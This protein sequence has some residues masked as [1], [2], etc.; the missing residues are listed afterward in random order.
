MKL[1]FN[2]GNQDINSEQWYDLCDS[3]FTEY[4]SDEEQ[5]KENVRNLYSIASFLPE[6]QKGIMSWLNEHKIKEHK[7]LG[8]SELFKFRTI[9]FEFAD[10]VFLSHREKTL[11]NIN[12]Q[13]EAIQ[14]LQQPLAD[15]IFE[16][17]YLG[18]IPH[19]YRDYSNPPYSQFNLMLEC[20]FKK[21]L[22][23][24]LYSEEY[25]N[26]V[27]TM[28]RTIIDACAKLCDDLR[29]YYSNLD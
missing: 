23:Y 8:E 17:R 3:I 28:R 13:I 12:E 27:M 6:A 26:E 10:D 18:P 24:E 14:K 9:F 22:E 4:S 29:R 15:K 2:K 25:Y 5:A 7:I 19:E 16:L 20:D 1:K 21:D 11:Y